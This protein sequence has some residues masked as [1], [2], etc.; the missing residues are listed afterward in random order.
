M[1]LRDSVPIY[2]TRSWADGSVAHYDMPVCMPLVAMLLI[3]LNVIVWGL[4]GL[5]EAVRVV[6]A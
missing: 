5:Y 1:S 4:L 3:W 6:L 2:V